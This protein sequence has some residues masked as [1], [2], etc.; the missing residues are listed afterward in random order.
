MNRSS[1]RPS[2][3]RRTPK[4]PQ[5]FGFAVKRLGFAPEDGDSL[6]AVTFHTLRHT[7]ASWLAQSGK[8]SLI[9]LQKLMRHANI[10]M[11]MRYAH[12]IPGQETEKLSVIEDILA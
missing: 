6:Y 8:V 7:F 9:E 3:A 10:N 4:L 5:P 12:L 11:T 1:R 2:P